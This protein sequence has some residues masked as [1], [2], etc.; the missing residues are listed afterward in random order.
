[1][2]SGSILL[3]IKLEQLTAAIQGSSGRKHSCPG[4]VDAGV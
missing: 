3:S 2:V 1:M 4:S